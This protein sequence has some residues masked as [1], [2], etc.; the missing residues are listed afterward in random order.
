LVSA[1]RYTL[2]SV[3]VDT[4]KRNNLGVLRSNP[5]KFVRQDSYR[6]IRQINYADYADRFVLRT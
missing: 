3:I 6:E 1:F 5:G 4:Q 2:M